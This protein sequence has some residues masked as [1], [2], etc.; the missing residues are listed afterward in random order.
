[1]IKDQKVLT[2]RELAGGNHNW[3]GFYNFLKYH[4]MVDQYFKIQEVDSATA[5]YLGVRR[6]KKK[7]IHTITRAKAKELHKDLRYFLEHKATKGSK[8]PHVKAVLSNINEWLGNIEDE[9]RWE[10]Q[11]GRTHIAPSL[12]TRAESGSINHV[13]LVFE[14]RVTVYGANNFEGKKFILDPKKYNLQLDPTI[15]NISNFNKPTGVKDKDL[16]TIIN[17]V[18][19]S[20]YEDPEYMVEASECRPADSV[21]YFKYVNNQPVYLFELIYGYN[22]K[23]EHAVVTRA[24]KIIDMGDNYYMECIL[25]SATDDIRL[26]LQNSCDVVNGT[27]SAVNPRRGIPSYLPLRIY[28]I[29][30]VE[31]LIKEG[32]SK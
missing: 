29:E 2:G 16:S 30:A 4:N 21:R 3:T 6:N 27:K 20:H 31:N 10:I 23:G 15:E 9:T 7:G 5:D 25:M 24:F 1:M 32:L 13:T 18:V 8:Y 17:I 26:I 11:L 12:I 19:D 22:Y 28:S 14:K